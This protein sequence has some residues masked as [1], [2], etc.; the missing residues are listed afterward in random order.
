MTDGPTDGLTDGHSLCENASNNG[1]NNLVH[2]PI[3]GLL[4]SLSGAEMEV[5]AEKLSF[6][7]FF[8]Q[9]PALVK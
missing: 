4:R 2:Q 3:W 9:I 6:N 8:T 5:D 7:P 1:Q